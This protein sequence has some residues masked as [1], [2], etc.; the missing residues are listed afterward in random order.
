[1]V[2]LLYFF[3]SELYLPL[4]AAHHQLFFS[5]LSWPHLLFPFICVCYSLLKASMQ[6]LMLIKNGF[7]LKCPPNSSLQ[8]IK[9]HPRLYTT[10][11][12]YN[13][14]GCFLLL[15]VSPGCGEY[16]KGLSEIFS[17]SWQNQWLLA[18]IRNHSRCVLLRHGLSN[19]IDFWVDLW[20][21]RLANWVKSILDRAVWKLQVSSFVALALYLGTISPG[22]LNL[23]V[24]WRTIFIMKVVGLCNEVFCHQLFSVT[25]LLCTFDKSNINE[26]S[27]VFDRP[28]VTQALPLSSSNCIKLSGQ[29]S[30][31]A[32]FL[33]LLHYNH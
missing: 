23:R 31:Y 30:I 7:S 22:V 6:I 12:L 10:P 27:S 17:D 15:P 16:R 9:A 28:L 29:F 18:C 2:F 13:P 1:M 20:M 8:V 11:R 33:L 4:C 14:H 3:K 19:L 5:L 25:I 21:F 26:H 32:V 24:S